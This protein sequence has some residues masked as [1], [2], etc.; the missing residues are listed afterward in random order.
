[1]SLSPSTTLTTS[2][3]VIECTSHVQVHFDD[4]CVLIPDP[5]AQSRM[6]RLVKKSYS[7]PL[8]K[9]RAGSQLPAGDA[10]LDPAIAASPPKDGGVTITVPVPSFA[11][12]RSPTRG[13][14]QHPPLM[15]CLVDASH[16]R[17]P[18]ARRPSLPLSPRPDAATVPLRPCCEECYPIT[19]ESLKGGADWQEKF[20][21][22]ARRRRN[23]SADDHA[24]QH[25]QRHRTVRDDLP[26]FGAVV[27]V[28]EVDRRHGI[29]R[30][31][32]TPKAPNNDNSDG[33]E[34]LL[35]SLSRLN[36]PTPASPKRIV[37]E[38]EDEYPFPHPSDATSGHVSPMLLQA[39]ADA[40]LLAQ[41]LEG[42][43]EDPDTLHSY[44]VVQRETIYYT[45]DSSPSLPALEPHLSSSDSPTEQDTGP[46][47]PKTPP[48]PS[49][50][51]I[52]IPNGGSHHKQWYSDFAPSV[53]EVIHR[54]EP[55]HH[56]SS[57][58]YDAHSTSTAS[59]E[60]ADFVPVLT[61]GSQRKKSFLQNL[62]SPGS[63]LRVGSDVFR[64][65][66]VPGTAMGTFA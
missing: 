1:M 35:P 24:H 33:E 36:I 17:R 5:V 43:C 27:S 41:H 44:S 3:A 20:T 8:W 66:S 64:G 45:P 47:T 42:E 58:H 56:R 23:S 55:P 26:G 10:E 4:S 61:S 7:L 51:P 37:E 48:A 12:S 54:E 52:S 49:T 34:Q 39:L 29:S 15:P 60:L 18:G 62:P 38:E 6:P 13:E 25:A 9:K 21:R 57:S 65:L 2:P 11:R 63:F 59:P 22:G 40:N 31:A 14:H 28:D 32:V 16:T 30:T 19:E 50:A 53:S 46:D